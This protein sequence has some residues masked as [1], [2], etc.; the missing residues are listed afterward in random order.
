M[1]N[2]NL[3]DIFKKTNAK[4]N[5]SSFDLSKRIAFSM[6]CGYLTPIYQ[7]PCVPNEH[8]KISLSGLL[9]TE[10]MNTAAFVSGKIHVNFFFV[11]YSQ[12][13]HPFN[14]FVS[15]KQDKHS[16]RYQSN[17][18]V[19]NVSLRSILTQMAN[20]AQQAAYNPS[21]SAYVYDQFGY[22]YFFHMARILQAFGYGNYW[23]MFGVE[24]QTLTDWIDVLFNKQTVPGK[25]PTYDDKYVN[26]FPILAYQHIFYDFYRNKYYDTVDAA[27]NDYVETFNVDDI[28]CGTV[29]NSHISFGQSNVRLWF[30]LHSIQ[31]KKDLF[32][33]LMPSSQFGPVSDVEF[34]TL[35]L[36]EADS[37]TGVDFLLN[38]DGS[39]LGAPIVEVD[40]SND[41]ASA[42]LSHASVFGGYSV[43]PK[44]SID[45]LTFQR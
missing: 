22:N 11:P 30:N 2:F 12:L 7:H 37:P 10:T 20:F 25:D 19:P 39:L 1:A 28:S 23:W 5:H 27:G 33:S 6:P 17:K 34:D 4:V 9:R 15:Q 38:S 26:M 42:P 13:W 44:G 35:Q 36:P 8:H 45:V 32:T 31:Y 29:N 21:G 40:S 43:Y 18:F 41:L 16:V 14:S 24:L 3:V